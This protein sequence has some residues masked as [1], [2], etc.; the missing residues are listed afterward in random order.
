MHAV[1]QPDTHLNAP[2]SFLRNVQRKWQQLFRRRR[3]RH[4]RMLVM[5]LS[6]FNFEGGWNRAFNPLKAQENVRV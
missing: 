5:S 1:A 2:N 4:D 6:A 3:E